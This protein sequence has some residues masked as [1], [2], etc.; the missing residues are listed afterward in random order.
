VP[1]ILWAYGPPN[2]VSEGDGFS[3]EYARIPASIGEITFL[4]K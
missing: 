4:A 2:F 3:D 1:T